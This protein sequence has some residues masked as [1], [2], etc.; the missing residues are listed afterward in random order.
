MMPAIPD[1]DVAAVTDHALGSRGLATA[2]PEAAAW[3]AAVSY[4]RHAFTDYDTMLAE[5]YGVEAARHFC[6]ADLNARLAAWG[7]R[8]R[9]GDAA[10]GT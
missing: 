10:D 6:L 7:C 3:L 5:G 2:S 9:V 1:K 4:A 8:R